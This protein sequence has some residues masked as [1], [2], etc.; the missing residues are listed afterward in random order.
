MDRRLIA[1][2]KSLTDPRRLRI[3][4]LLAE[5]EATVEAIADRTDT[6]PAAVAHHLARLRSAGLVESLGRWPTARYRFRPERLN[7]LG[8]SLDGLER[9]G[10]E[11]PADV[12]APPGRELSGEEAR[13]L[14]GFLEADRLT[15]IPAQERKRLV[16]LRYLR[17]RCFSEDR[18][19]PEKEV[20][21]LL[22]VF[23]PDV[24]SL[25]RYLVDSGLMTRSAGLYRR[26]GD[27]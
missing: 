4:A 2:L 24:A 16:V 20:N 6:A 23:H 1:A 13:I 22:A 15:T 27:G 18:A 26:A 17:D 7:E 8:K 14:S 25:R 10:D 12:V 9:E 5:G 11:T 19:Y 21:Q 3:V